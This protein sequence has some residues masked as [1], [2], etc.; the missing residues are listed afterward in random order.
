[1]LRTVLRDAGIVAAPANQRVFEAWS[2]VAG[3]LA[4]HAE[5]VRFVRGTLTVEVDSATHRH[6]LENFTGEGLRKQT[7]RSLGSML[8]R[9][10]V[11][12]SRG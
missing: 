9:K 2:R 7:N 4:R 6:E 3:P 12:K 10:V 1:M 11:F 5:P 8:V